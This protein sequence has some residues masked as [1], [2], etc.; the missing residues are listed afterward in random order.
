MFYLGFEDTEN[1]GTIIYAPDG[2]LDPV[3]VALQEFCQPGARLCFGNIIR[4]QKHMITMIAA[5]EKNLRH[6]F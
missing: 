2:I 6:N 5:R 3:A 4:K 1:P